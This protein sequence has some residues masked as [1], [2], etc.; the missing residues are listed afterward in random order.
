MTERNPETYQRVM[1]SGLLSVPMQQV[2][3]AL[4]QFP[5]GLTKGELEL[6]LRQNSVSKDENAP[7]DKQ[8]GVMVKMGIVA[9]GDKKHCPAKNKEDA[10]WRLTSSLPTKPKAGKPSAKRYKKAVEQLEAI[11]SQHRGL[12]DGM[13]TPEVQALYEWVKDKI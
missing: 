9:K 5:Q 2:Y 12:G 11:L 4:W 13:V 8:V 1:G 7:W 6:F 3:W 10:T